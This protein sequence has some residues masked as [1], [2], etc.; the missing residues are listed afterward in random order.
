MTLIIR[1]ILFT[2]GFIFLY[3]SSFLVLFEFDFGSPQIRHF[4]TTSIFFTIAVLIFLAALKLEKFWLYCPIFFLLFSGI[5]RFIGSITI[6][7]WV[8]D[9]TTLGGEF[10]FAFLLIILCLVLRTIKHPK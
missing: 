9:L 5:F 4:S 1:T 8:L 2:L 6:D 3:F 7:T 10:F